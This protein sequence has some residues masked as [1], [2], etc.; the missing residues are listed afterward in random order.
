MPRV[1]IRAMLHYPLQEKLGGEVVEA[2]AREGETLGDF[3]HRFL[4]SKGCED[5]VFSGDRIKSHIIVMLNMKN[6][7]MTGGLKSKLKE[8][9]EITIVPAIAGG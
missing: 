9:D 8:G 2:E 3:L 6:I 4:N 5:I 7:A 1:K